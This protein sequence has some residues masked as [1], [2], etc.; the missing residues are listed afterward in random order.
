MAQALLKAVNI[1][2][3][4]AGV[5][6]LKGVSLEIMPGEVHCLAGENGCGKSTLIK[7]ISGVHP[8]DG[9]TLEFNGQAMDSLL[10]LMP[11]WQVS[12]FTAVP[13]RS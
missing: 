11:L 7:V 10:P 4:F 8:R 1:T 12:C 6:A 3:S 5:Q 2:K 13:T 9:G